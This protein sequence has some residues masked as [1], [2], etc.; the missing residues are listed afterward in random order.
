MKKWVKA[1]LIMFAVSL[2]T[3]I[4]VKKKEVVYYNVESYKETAVIKENRNEEGDFV[5]Y[6][7]DK[8]LLVFVSYQD[9]YYID[10]TDPNNHKTLE[11]GKVRIYKLGNKYYVSSKDIKKANIDYDVV[12]KVK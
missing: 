3:I 8:D 4:V 11:L 6:K 1:V 5:V 10:K 2:V 12:I 7:L 9:L